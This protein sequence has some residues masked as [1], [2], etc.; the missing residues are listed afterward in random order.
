MRILFASLLFLMA[1]AA[2]AAD[3]RP[4]APVRSAAAPG[5]YGLP[6]TPLQGADDLAGLSGKPTVIVL[7]QPDCPWCLLQFKESNKVLADQPDAQIVAVSLRGSRSAL[8]NE[9][10]KGRAQVPAYRGSPALIKALGDPEGTPRTYV[11]SANGTLLAQG[12]GLQKADKLAMVL[13]ALE[14]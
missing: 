10:R 9:L 2:L 14:R 11:I 12:R 4:N 1:P 13:G 8:L 7:F 5:L 6:A 3:I